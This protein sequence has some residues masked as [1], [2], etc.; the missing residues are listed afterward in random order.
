MNLS[1]GKKLKGLR[2]SKGYTLKKLSDLSG[3]SVSFISDI[4]NGR[5]NPSI[6]NLQ[7][8]CNAL[9]VDISYFFDDVNR[10]C[11]EEHKINK[12]ENAQYNE[13]IKSAGEFFMNDGVAEEDKEKIFKDITELFWKSKEINK[14]KYTKKK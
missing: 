7:K 8:I 11:S 14:K 1:I 6:E 3:I 13:F 4:E 12:N 5:R 10:N 9:S 2:N